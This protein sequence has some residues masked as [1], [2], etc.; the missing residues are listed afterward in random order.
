MVRTLRRVVDAVPP[1][2]T[3]GAG[4]RRSRWGMRMV[5][6]GGGGTYREMVVQW[7]I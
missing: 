1:T 7:S 3:T 5:G 4:G 2:C 6:I